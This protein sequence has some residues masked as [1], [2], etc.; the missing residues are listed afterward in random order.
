MNIDDVGTRIEV[1]AEDLA[2]YL[3]SADGFASTTEQ[4]LE[5]TALTG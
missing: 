2:E 3:R 1:V 5:Q 4:K